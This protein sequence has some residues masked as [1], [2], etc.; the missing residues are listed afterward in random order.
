MA[1]GACEKAPRNLNGGGVNFE[2]RISFRLKSEPFVIDVSTK[3]PA[4][5]IDEVAT[6]DEL[7]EIEFTRVQSASDITDMAVYITKTVNGTESLVTADWNDYLASEG[8]VT[9]S[10]YWPS[11]DQNYSFYFLATGTWGNIYYSGTHFD[12]N[13]GNPRG[14][15]DVGQFYDILVGHDANPSYHQTNTADLEHLTAIVNRSFTVN[16]PSGYTVTNSYFVIKNAVEYGWY[17]FKTGTVEAMHQDS[18]P[19]LVTGYFVNDRGEAGVNRNICNLLYPSDVSLHGYQGFERTFECDRD[20]YG[21]ADW[22]WYF[23][24]GIALIRGTYDVEVHFTM[25]KGEYSETFTRTIPVTFEG[26]KNNQ[27]I[28][29]VTMNPAKAVDFELANVPAWSDINVSAT[30]AS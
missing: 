1:V 6:H 30:I 5:P 7:E 10:Q 2:D 17:Y 12:F 4:T 3:G 26:G 23:D 20:D 11:R 27:L 18:Q 25:N 28:L 22:Y 14:W 24:A 29:N 19:G 9:T 15:V 8:E 16:V 13:N 21:Y